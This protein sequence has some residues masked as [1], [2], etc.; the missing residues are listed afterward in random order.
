ML[1]LV[2]LAAAAAGAAPSCGPVG[3]YTVTITA[4]DPVPDGAALISHINGSTAFNF[5]FTTAWFPAPPGRTEG[6]IVR[7]VEC[8]TNHHPCPQ[9]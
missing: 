2:L 9:V 4:R 3:D 8:S 1:A 6:L 7:N 5:S